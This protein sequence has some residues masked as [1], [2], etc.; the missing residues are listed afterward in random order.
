[1]KKKQKKL[2]ADELPGS[3][4]KFSFR[5]HLLPPFIG[6]VMAFAVFG[7]M[8]SQIIVAK[9]S[10]KTYQTPAP[11]ATVPESAP[12][13]SAPKIIIN[14]I[15]VKAPVI[16][17]QRTVDEG[18]FQYA[19]RSGVVHY[20]NTAL[21]GKPGNVVIFGH[22]SGQVWA[23]GDY[24]FIFT[25][26]EKLKDDDRIYIEYEGVRYIYSITGS[27]VVP[28][29]QMSVLN[30]TADNTLTLITCTPVGTSKNRLIVTAKQI[31]PKPEIV[32]EEPV[33]NVQPTETS[34]PNSQ[35]PSLWQSIQ[36]W[37]EQ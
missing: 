14:S 17:D 30:P 26:L 29:T 35:S 16:Y 25:H 6:L 36:T 33:T 15:G 8:N 27:K 32:A 23:P 34:L 18:A 12:V 21:P 20:P 2:K 5:R 31:V 37:L 22:S 19:L 9:I 7:L 11:T 3:R 13:D 10:E 28:P 4:V 24:K 1:M